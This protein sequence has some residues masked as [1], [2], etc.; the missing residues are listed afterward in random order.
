MKNTKTSWKSFWFLFAASFGLMYVGYSLFVF[1][2]NPYN[3]FPHNLTPTTLN[4]AQNQRFSY[5]AI[6]RNPAY[7]SL[8]IGTSTSRL[9]QPAILDEGLERSFA[10]LSMNSAT[11]YEQY[12]IAEHFIN[13][14]DR[15]QDLIVGVDISWCDMNKPYA[16]YTSRPFPEWMY[17]SSPWNDLTNHYSLRTLEVSLKKAAAMIG[18]KAP[19]YQANGYENFLVDDSL[20]DLEKVRYSLYGQAQP[21]QKAPLIPSQ[22]LSKDARAALSFPAF[23]YLTS[24]LEVIPAHTR[25]SFIFVPYHHYTLPAKGSTAASQWQECKNRFTQIAQNRPNSVVIDFMKPS[26]FTLEDTHYWDPLHYRLQP[27]YDLTHAI[28][29]AIKG[30]QSETKFYDILHTGQP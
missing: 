23:P 14:H 13:H 10:I 18:L 29:H 5:P 7:N 1:I 21:K 2:L 20:Y 8:V 16:Q 3:I 9:F 4:M 25:V 17:D 26:W 30:M 19:L 22:T 28:V 11:A 27:S 6:A 15:V 12:K 24:L